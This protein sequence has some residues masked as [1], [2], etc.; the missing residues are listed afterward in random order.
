MYA[1][2]GKSS[3]IQEKQQLFAEVN[4]FQKALILFS[5]VGVLFVFFAADLTFLAVGLMMFQVILIYLRHMR[6]SV[7]ELRM[8]N[9]LEL[10]AKMWPSQESTY[11]V[12]IKYLV[13]IHQYTLE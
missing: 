3:H 12:D 1:K 9:R 6:E 2:E 8:R 10:A 11:V 5:Q 4:I 7:N 13:C